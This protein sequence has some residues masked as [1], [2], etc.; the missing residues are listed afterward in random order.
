MEKPIKQIE[1]ILLYLESRRIAKY[2]NNY[3]AMGSCDMP[4][5][6]DERFYLD[7]QRSLE[8]LKNWISTDGM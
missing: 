2:I 4:I 1:D 3:F 5:T 8:K 7:N 6:E